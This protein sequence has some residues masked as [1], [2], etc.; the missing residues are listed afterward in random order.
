MINALNLA[1]EYNLQCYTEPHL[2]KRKKARIVFELIQREFCDEY[3]YDIIAVPDEEIS[4]DDGKTW[5]QS[6]LE[7]ATRIPEKSTRVCHR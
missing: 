3:E 5:R 6:H 4:L 1:F 7:F 2:N